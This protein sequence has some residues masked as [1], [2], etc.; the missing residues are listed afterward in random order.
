MMRFGTIRK[1]AGLLATSLIAVAAAAQPG[2]GQGSAQPAPA[3]PRLN[4]PQDINFGNMQQA[5]RVARATAIVNDEIITQTDI[6]QRLALLLVGQRAQLPEAEMEAARAQIL[7]GLIDEALQIQAARERKIEV[8]RA[9]LDREYARIAQQNG[10]TARDFGKFLTSIGSS[11]RS[12]RRQILGEL[13][14]DELLQRITR[15][16]VTNEEVKETLDRLSASRGTREYRVVEIFIKAEPGA[17]P[18]ARAE[19][20]RVVQ[21]I[22]GGAQFTLVA[23]QV[24]DASTAAVGGDLGWTRIDQLPTE[25]ASVVAAMPVGAISEPIQVQGGFSIVGLQDARQVLMADPRDAQLNLMQMS[26]ELPA[27][28]TEPQARQRAQQLAQAT[29]NMGGCGRAAE[30]AQSIGADLVSNDSMKIRDL[31]PQMQPNILQL[32]V[33]QATAP[34]GSLERVSV[35]ILCG[36]D[37][38]EDPKAPTL[39]AVQDNLAQQRMRRQAQRYIRDLRRDAI[40]EYR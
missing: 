26:F 32:S 28:T 29:Q 16:S 35:L 9:A 21:Q 30:T 18:Q 25:L 27:G 38:P 8:E 2:G 12:L 4:I 5:R 13:S 22:R 31:P 3:A 34:F 7:R 24:S 33:G 14:W 11:E 23:R 15:V 20:E 6:D 17:E 1:V 40:I 37:D 36:R 19:A 10:H 39:A